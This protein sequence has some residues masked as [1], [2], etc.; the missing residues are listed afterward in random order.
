M[1]AIRKRSTVILIELITAGFITKDLV[2]CHQKSLSRWYLTSYLA[3][4]ELARRNSQEAQRIQC[5]ESQ[6]V[7]KLGSNLPPLLDV[8]AV[9]VL[10]MP[11]FLG[12]IVV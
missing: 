2:R 9:F 8:S 10:R 1:F 4:L 5:L 7:V 3:E 6:F 12:E 11:A